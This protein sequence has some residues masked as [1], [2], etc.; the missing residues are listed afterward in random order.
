MSDYITSS[1]NIES[2]ISSAADDKEGEVEVISSA[3][4]G[5]YRQDSDRTTGYLAE[6][7]AGLLSSDELSDETNQGKVTKSTKAAGTN[8]VSLLWSV[9]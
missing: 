7:E 6:D 3:C 4:N 8:Q 1:K 5:N 9:T 2:A